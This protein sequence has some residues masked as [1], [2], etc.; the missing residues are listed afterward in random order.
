[1]FRADDLGNCKGRKR[2]RK[3]HIHREADRIQAAATAEDLTAAIRAGAAAAEAAAADI[4]AVNA[5]R[6]RRL[7]VPRD[8]FI[9]K[10]NRFRIR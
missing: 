5:R 4:I 9:T 6:P 2:K 3:C 8:I 10:R 7:R 1:M